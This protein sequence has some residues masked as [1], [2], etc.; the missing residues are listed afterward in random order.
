[1]LKAC[2]PYLTLIP[3]PLIVQSTSYVN[4]PVKQP[5]SMLYEKLFG[6]ILVVHDR[7][8]RS[9]VCACLTT[10]FVPAL[11]NAISLQSISLIEYPVPSIPNHV[12]LLNVVRDSVWSYFLSAIAGH[13]ELF[14]SYSENDI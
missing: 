11:V 14:F 6:A 9:Y 3:G 10:P 5:Y 7:Y 8:N 2:R 13:S 1:M 4:H 12:A